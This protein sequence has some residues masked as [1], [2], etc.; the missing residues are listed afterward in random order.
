MNVKFQKLIK[1]YGL[2]ATSDKV[3]GVEN[4]K[5]LLLYSSILIFRV[6]RFILFSSPTLTRSMTP[7]YPACSVDEES[8]LCAHLLSDRSSDLLP[9]AV[10]SYRL[11][12]VS[13]RLSL[14]R[15]FSFLG[16]FGCIQYLARLEDRLAG[17]AIS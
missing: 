5:S 1:I 11:L 12:L 15:S 7:V 9:V 10:C 16:P 14:L 8:Q 4:T 17:L 13:S 3:S 2:Y 6:A